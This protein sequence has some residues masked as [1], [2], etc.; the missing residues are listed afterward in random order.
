MPSNLDDYLQQGIHGKK[1]LNP[2][3]RRKFLGT[4]RER[5]VLAL[6]QE[7]VYEKG[8]YSE[9]ESAFRE[10]PKAHLL[11]NGHIDYEALSKY[12]KIANKYHIAYKIVTDQDHNSEIGLVITYDE[13]IDKE[14]IYVEKQPPAPNKEETKKSAFSFL[15]KFF[16]K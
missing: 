6:M 14:S 16:Q 5:I 12:I 8:V 2:E 15:K 4:L 13:A 9:V 3:E 7:Q 11:L 10:H 1:E